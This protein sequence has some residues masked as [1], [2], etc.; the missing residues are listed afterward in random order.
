MGSLLYYVSEA[1]NRTIVKIKRHAKYKRSTLEN[2]IAV[3]ELNKPYILSDYINIVK[4]PSAF[5]KKLRKCTLVGHGLMRSLNGIR[6]VLGMN[7]LQYENITLFT[8][9]DLKNESIPD[10]YLNYNK[11]LFSVRKSKF[12][13]IAAGDRGGPLVCRGLQYGILS[14][15][16]KVQPLVYI[17]RYVRSS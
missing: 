7:P 4:L 14:L 12:G 17:N 6:V 10:A 8:A 15:A 3:A 13:Y 1:H 5:A 2:D 11:N 16:I 9:V